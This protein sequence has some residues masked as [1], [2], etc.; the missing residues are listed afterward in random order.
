MSFCNIILKTYFIFRYLIEVAAATAAGY[1][2]FSAQV[3][4]PS[5]PSVTRSYTPTPKASLKVLM[6]LFIMVIFNCMH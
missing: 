1:G 2:P 3:S 4:V 6:M 5:V